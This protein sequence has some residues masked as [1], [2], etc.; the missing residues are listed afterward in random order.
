MSSD[1]FTQVVAKS[2]SITELHVPSIGARWDFAA[3]FAQALNNNPK[4]SLTSFDMS[5][6]FLEDKGINNLST[7]LSKMP[8][9]LH[10]VNLS[11]CSL[12]PKVRENILIY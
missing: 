4:S 7:V 11:Y 12:T 3:K 10:H 2:I 1:S 9:G 5:C 6:N 8:R